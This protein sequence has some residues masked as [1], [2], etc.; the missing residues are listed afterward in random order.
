MTCDV[1]KKYLQNYP[2]G[3]RVEFI[4]IIGSFDIVSGSDELCK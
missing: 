3:F 4:E 1:A 2:I